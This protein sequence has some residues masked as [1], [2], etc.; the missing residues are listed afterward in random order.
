M[1]YPKFKHLLDIASH[2][3]LTCRTR[4]AKFTR[5]QRCCDWPIREESVVYY[6]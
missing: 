4:Y 1:S 2:V 3:K 6:A 5:S